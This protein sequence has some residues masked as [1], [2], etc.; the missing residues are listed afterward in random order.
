V[1]TV[2]LVGH[3]AISLVAIVAGFLAVFGLLGRKILNRWT[4]LF[5]ATTTATSFTGFLFP[6]HHFMPSHG[7]GIISLIALGVAIYAF[8]SRKL[9]GA[10]RKT[11]AV[12]AVLS[13]YLN[14]FVLIVQSFQKIPALKALAPTQTEAPFKFTQLVVLV[15]FVVVVILAAIRIPAQPAQPN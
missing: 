13:L 15:A 8:Y 6:V 11:Y 5:L 1:L 3:I 9:Q 2:L 14:V 4:A 10:W 12:T 7:A